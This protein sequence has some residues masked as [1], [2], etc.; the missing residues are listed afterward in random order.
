[1]ILS[2]VAMQEAMDQGRLSIV[3]VPMPKRPGESQP[4]P[5]DTHSVNLCLGNELA[6]P[7]PGTYCFDLG[8]KGD[9]SFFLSRNSAKRTIPTEGFPLDVRQFVLGIT[10]ERVALP[11]DHPINKERGVCLAARIEGRSSVARCGVLVHFTAPTIH[12]GFEG[13]L[14]LEIINLGPARFMLRPGMPI[15]QLIVEEVLGIPFVKADRQFSGQNTPEG[16][17]SSA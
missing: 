4:C 5:Y 6:I 2:N 15:A 11:V 9:L 3:P 8:Q 13:T 1:M 14:T 7:E 12:P 17:R 10:R 16:M